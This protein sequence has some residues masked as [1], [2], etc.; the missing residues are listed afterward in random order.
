VGLIGE[1]QQTEK[2]EL[3]RNATRNPVSAERPFVAVASMEGI[4]VN[5]H[6]GEAGQLWI[7]GMDRGQ[8]KLMENRPTPVA[9][10]VM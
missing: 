10:T 9:G 2:I 5:Q 4:F 8:I 1:T 6:L 3:L 7:F